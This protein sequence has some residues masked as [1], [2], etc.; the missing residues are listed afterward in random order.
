[1]KK[2][3][4]A[5]LSYD[6]IHDKVFVRLVLDEILNEVDIDECS[7]VVIE[8]DNCSSQYKWSGHF[9]DIKNIANEKTLLSVESTEL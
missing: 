3:D 5:F 7:A 6:K 9:S 2:R 8:S 1:M 4:Q